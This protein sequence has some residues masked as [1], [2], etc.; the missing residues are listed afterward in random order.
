MKTLASTVRNPHYS[1][2][3]NME[4]TASVL[5]IKSLLFIESS[6]GGFSVWQKAIV[7][8]GETTP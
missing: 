3:Q 8:L 6:E 7:V 5:F 1:H 2:S 4:K